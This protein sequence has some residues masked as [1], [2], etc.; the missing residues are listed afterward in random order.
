MKRF[1]LLQLLLA[2]FIALPFVAAKDAPPTVVTHVAEAKKSETAL[3]FAEELHLVL[4]AP[5]NGGPDCEWQITSN[6]PRVLRLSGEPKA[7]T[8]ADLAAAA[9][10]T[11]AP[12]ASGAW[13]ATF[14]ALR[15]G[16]SVVRLVYVRAVQ[17]GEAT[18]LATREIN[19]VV[20][21]R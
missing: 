12:L 19:V 8:P 18:S 3:R 1:T 11:G 20:N 17:N 14:L 4:P 10:K 15:P 13:T 2:A 16:R 5:A 6:D 9:E 7:A 21:E